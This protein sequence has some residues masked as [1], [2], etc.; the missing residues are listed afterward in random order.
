MDEHVNC[1]TTAKIL[2]NLLE[3]LKEKN[4]IT[5]EEG[6]KIMRRALDES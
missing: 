6:R 4:I 5:T 3:L 2:A 1:L